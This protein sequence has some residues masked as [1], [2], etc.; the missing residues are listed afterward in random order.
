[1]LLKKNTIPA[2]VRKMTLKEAEVLSEEV[3]RRII[4]VTLQNGGHIGASL[5]AVELIV[6]LLRVFDPDRDKIV[7]DVG[8]QA[9]AYKI[10][11]GRNGEF[12]KLRTFGGISGFPK[13]SESK[14][15]HFVG[16][17][18]G[19]AVSAGCG[20]AMARSLSKEDYEI[21]S[22]IG[23]GVTVNGET[24]EGLNLATTYGKQ[25]IVINDNT[26]SIS[27][28][29]G[30]VPQYLETLRKEPYEG[31]VKAGADSPFSIYDLD[32]LGPVPGH[33]IALLDQAFR[34]AKE[35]KRSLIV[36]VVTN[37]GKGFAPAE[38]NPLKLHGVSPKGTDSGEGFGGVFGRVLS[39]LR[40]KDDKVV[41]VAAAMAIGTG[42]GDF[43]RKYPDSFTD[44]GIA[45]S[46]AVTVAASLARSGYKPY[47]ALYSTFL[48]RAYDQLLYDVALDGLDVTII[49]DRA[50]LVGEDGESHQGIY[51]LALL[52][53][54]PNV[55]I[56]SPATYSE[57]A[58][59]L[60]YLH[61]KHGVKIIRYPKGACKA[62]LPVDPDF[63]R[64]TT[65]RA[66]GGAGAIVTH[67][68]AMIEVALN[69]A[70]ILSSQGIDVGVINARF[71]LP[72]D[73][74][75]LDSLSNVPLYVLE[76]VVYE[77]SLSQHLSAM[78]Y[79]VTPFTLPNTYVTF[80]KP[81]ELRAAYSID[82]DSVAEAIRN[83]T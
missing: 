83:A 80:G 59:M 36:H 38:Q 62:D 14:Y 13:P 34:I 20:Y 60:P 25:I 1:M 54:V 64:W 69:A 56:A 82:A 42:L 17:H 51:D 6:A 23:D 29:V 78:G 67:G 46:T 63:P 21:I 15:D 39:E 37:K 11:T 3:R 22:V 40:E 16:G 43:A 48:Q 52:S 9:Y 81:S 61:D 27:A 50:G 8:H 35:A 65:L 7:F 24:A 12:D 19:N 28:G 74:S 32:Y 58:A 75:Y 41:A 57:L 18:A 66:V 47:V 77:G 31:K 33:D 5:G 2:D 68:A 71:L 26:Y 55:T 30:S 79:R 44:V 53:S 70:E 49:L 45:E 73:R 10:L 76:D 4:E 72:L